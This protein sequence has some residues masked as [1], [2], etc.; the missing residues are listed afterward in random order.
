VRRIRSRRRLRLICRT[1]IGNARPA[2][3]QRDLGLTNRQY[4]IAL[5]VTYVPYIVAELPLTLAL[6]KMYVMTGPVRLTKIELIYS[7]PHILLPTL[8]VSWGIVCTFQGFV[9]NYSGLLAVR[10]F[11]GLTEGA[12]L[13]VRHLA[14]RN[15][16]ELIYQGSITYLSIFYCRAELGKRVA[17]FFSATSLAGAFSGLLAAAI[18]NMD[19]KGGKA[20]WAWIFILYVIFSFISWHG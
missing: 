3:L 7:G 14:Q 1:N 2:G 19:G 12:I 15:D 8:V 13:P 20:G 11:L 4:S 5:T 10:F 17:I 9:H 6:K 16:I 18:L